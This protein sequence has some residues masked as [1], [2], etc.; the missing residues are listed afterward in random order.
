MSGSPK[1]ASRWGRMGGVVRRASSVLVATR[2]STPSIASDRDA[3]ASSLRNQRVDTTPAALTPPPAPV[4]HVPSPI[5]ES[6]ARE[7]AASQEEVAPLGPSPLAR[8][9]DN[10]VPDPTE[11]TS[12]VGYIP[13]PV[14]DSSAGNPGAFTDEPEDLPQP[15]VITDPFASGSTDGHS[16]SHH[17]VLAPVDVP[18]GVE[19]QELEQVPAETHLTEEAPAFEASR[20][21]QPPVVEEH[22]DPQPPVV[23]ETYHNEE[24]RTVDIP[25][26]EIQPEEVHTA[27][28]MPQVPV[29]SP[30]VSYFDNP[31]VQ[32]HGDVD[33]I[34]QPSIT[35]VEPVHVGSSDVP[36]AG[37]AD[38]ASRDVAPE[39]L[40]REVEHFDGGMVEHFD[41]PV[42]PHEQHQ[43]EAPS[44]TLP[45][46][47]IHSDQEIWGGNN[48]AQP[49]ED[50][51][52]TE[53]PRE[54]VE[55][56]YPSHASSVRSV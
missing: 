34:N 29:F 36:D 55:P 51:R 7:A 47:D 4:T 44:Y 45:N 12:P 35:F 20:D 40:S 37:P 42:P 6:P 22:Q 5:A 24:T 14:I 23:E 15:T 18:T 19:S 26:D 54:I 53:M 38:V 31:M 11:A 2:P 30:P 48:Q 50:T 25:V 9:E 49:Y 39:V 33:S 43:S 32:S 1:P 13:P 56:S 41:M 52:P 8:N 27:V 17:E 46:Y 10:A 3:D 28:E 21:I 16:T